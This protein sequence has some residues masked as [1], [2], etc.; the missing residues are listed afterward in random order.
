[1]GV[2]EKQ[3]SLKITPITPHNKDTLGQGIKWLKE[4]LD[5][6]ITGNIQIA[7]Q[8]K[9]APTVYI[10]VLGFPVSFFFFLNQDFLILTK[11]SFFS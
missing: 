2:G 4:N 11:I 10:C 7:F 5:L 1:M 9:K 3:T 8:D 6:T